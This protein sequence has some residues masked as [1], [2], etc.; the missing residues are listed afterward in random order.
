MKLHDNEILL[1][2]SLHGLY[3]K[4]SEGISSKLK[5]KIYIRLSLIDNY[6]R[7]NEEAISLLDKTIT[8]DEADYAAMRVLKIANKQLKHV[9]DEINEANK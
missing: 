5:F 9:K 7:Q 6:I 1:I 2:D 8:K 4:F 3:P